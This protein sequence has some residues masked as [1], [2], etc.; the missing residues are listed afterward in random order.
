MDLAISYEYY[1]MILHGKMYRYRTKALSVQTRTLIVQ[2]LL[3]QCPVIV[4]MSMIWYRYE[5]R[6]GKCLM[7]ELYKSLVSPKFRETDTGVVPRNFCTMARC[8]VLGGCWDESTL[9]SCPSTALN[10]ATGGGIVRVLGYK[11]CL[12][13]KPVLYQDRF[14]SLTYVGPGLDLW[15]QLTPLLEKSLFQGT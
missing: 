12:D 1:Y 9:S 13:T 11:T 4:F 8:G 15:W 6:P 14:C 10:M 7:I 5:F 3:N 2:I